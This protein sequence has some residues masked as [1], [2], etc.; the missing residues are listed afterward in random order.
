MNAH[1]RRH[2][3]SSARRFLGGGK[4]SIR[5][6]RPGPGR[7]GWALIAVESGDVIVAATLNHSVVTVLAKTK[8]RVD[9]MDFEGNTL[10]SYMRQEAEKYERSYPLQQHYELG[11]P[12]TNFAG[13]TGGGKGFKGAG[14]GAAAAA[15]A[16]TTRTNPAGQ[17]N[18]EADFDPWL[19]AARRSPG[20]DRRGP[21]DGARGGVRR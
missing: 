16:P 9:S 4:P 7:P 13:P 11:D 18:G 3:P 10:L 1:P 21:E 17:R 5:T 19:G 15:S 2:T 8:F 6:V 12:S 14:R 20:G